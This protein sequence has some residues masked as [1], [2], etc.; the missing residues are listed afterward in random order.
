MPYVSITGLRV[1]AL[2]RWPQ[3]SWH[4][5]R[6]M[7]QAKRA[8]GCI[9]AE[10][11]RIDGVQH[12]LSVWVNRQSMLQFMM[13]AFRLIAVGSTH[14]YETDHVPDWVEAQRL[15]RDNGKVY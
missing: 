11:R 6:S 15:W 3:F 2:W 14:G 9:H 5:V 12:T 13:R 8:E 7:T 10:A 4:A 1:K